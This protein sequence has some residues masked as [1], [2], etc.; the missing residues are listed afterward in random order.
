M[1]NLI[2]TA[3]NK[4][5]TAE[6]VGSLMLLGVFVLPV[7]GLAGSDKIYVD[8]NAS[9]TQ[10]GSSKHP[11]K[12]INEAMK[13]ADSDTQIHVSAGKYKESFE[14]REGVEVYGSEREDVVIE[15]PDDD[16]AVVTLNSNTKIDGVTVR[17]GKYGFKVGTNDRASIVNC[18]VED[19]DGHGILIEKGEAWDTRSV[20]ISDTLIRENGGAGIYSEK[21]RVSLVDNEIRDNDGDGV[22][23]LPGV[24]AWLDNNTVKNNDKS[25]LKMYLDGSTIW[26][27]RNIYSDNNREGIEIDAYGGSGRIDINDSEFRGNDRWGIAR[28]QRGNFSTSLWNSVTIQGSNYFTGNSYGNISNIVIIK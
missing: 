10:D 22:I 28:V 20:S 8:D 21:R 12:T 9:G 11:Y 25:G 24:S 19:N 15:S 26:T 14:V 4:G 5:K 23:L 18:I 1:K 17:N 3:L 2:K 27:K 6:I 7:L 13:H 16:W